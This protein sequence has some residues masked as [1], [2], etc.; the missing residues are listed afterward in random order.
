MKNRNEKILDV[1]IETAADDALFQEM[2]E[3]PSCEELDK[4]YK[5]SPEM[6]KRIKRLITRT[7]N[8]RK[9]K[10]AVSFTGKIA[11]SALSL[12]VVIITILFSVEASRNYIFNTFI[13][14]YDDHS[15]I[16]F[17]Q[18]ETPNNFEKY[19]INYIP[20]GFEV[21]NIISNELGRQ[22]TYRN[23]IGESIILRES[24]ADSL[25]LDIDNERSN[26]IVIRVNDNEA[27]L[28]KSSHDDE[29]NT[30]I[31]NDGNVVFTLITSISTD[32][33]ILIAESIKKN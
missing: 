12:F 27:Y 19:S 18:N 11:A 8:T 25:N 26:S 20:K 31:W 14:W 6:D 29:I 23:S 24:L 1:L 9:I 3:L 22:F 5:P 13:K 15:K 32:E 16:E 17:Q 21:N 7:E 28:F 30:L 10:K 4:I 33:M 2:S